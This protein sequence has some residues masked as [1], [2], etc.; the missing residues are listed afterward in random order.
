MI[1]RTT[2][3]TATCG[4]NSILLDSYDIRSIYALTQLPLVHGGFISSPS[5]LRFK[6]LTLE[7]KL[8]HSRLSDLTAFTA[9]L[10]SGMAAMTLDGMTF[11]GCCLVQSRLTDRCDSGI[12][13][14]VLKIR[15]V[16]NGHT[17]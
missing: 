3:C 11:Q 7:G 8:P 15:S 9:P 5:G 10:E 1:D 2:F 16:E 13:T 14:F 4:G 12:D 17:T 6:E